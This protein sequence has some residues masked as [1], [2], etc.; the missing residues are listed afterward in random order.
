MSW[1]TPAFMRGERSGACPRPQGGDNPPPHLMS[2]R[3]ERS[4]LVLLMP[5]DYLSIQN[6]TPNAVRGE[7]P[8]AMR[9]EVPH[10]MWVEGGMNLVNV[11]KS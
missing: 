11:L 5:L 6:R 4:N 1:F 3:A 2:L 7:I 8:H 10:A 9:G